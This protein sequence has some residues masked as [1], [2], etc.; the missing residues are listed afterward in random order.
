MESYLD[1][2]LMFMIFEVFFGIVFRIDFWKHFLT[3]NNSKLS[4][5]L[6]GAH[7]PFS[8]FFEV[9]IFSRIFVAFGVTFDR[10]FGTLWAHFSI[11]LAQIGSAGARSVD[12]LSKKQGTIPSQEMYF[13]IACLQRRFLQ[14]SVFT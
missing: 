13:L 6:S 10:P 9:A 14:N 2:Y 4:L 7:P 1:F 12:E 5:K 8:T 11:L 3:K